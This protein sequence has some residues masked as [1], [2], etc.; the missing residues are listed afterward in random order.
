[1]GKIFFCLLQLVF[2]FPLTGQCQQDS[3]IKNILSKVKSFNT[4]FPTE[5][6]YLQFDKPYYAAGDT[7]YFKVYVTLGQEHLLSTKSSVI[8]IELIDANNKINKVIKLPLTGGITW[9]DITLP[10]SLSMGNYRIRAFTRWMRNEGEEVFFD[11]TIPIGN[12]GAANVPN[13]TKSTSTKKVNSQNDIQFL[14]EGGELVSGV[15]CKVAFKALDKE[16]KGIEV[17]GTITDKNKQITSFKSNP[18]GMG[19][20]NMNVEEGTFYKANIVYADGSRNIS[21]LPK[22][23]ER[24]VSLAVIDSTAKFTVAINSSKSYYR[25]N[26]NKK[27]FL[28][29]LEGGKAVTVK[30]GLDSTTVKFDV[31][32]QYLHSGVM[33]ITLF[34][35][36][37]EPL[38]ERLVFVQNPDLLKLSVINQKTVYGKHEKVLINL[39][40]TNATVI[41]VVG[42]FSVSVTDEGKVPLTDSTGQNI[43]TYLLLTSDLK[44]NIEKPGQYFSNTEEARKDLDVLM[45]THGYRRF[46][47]KQLL[48][49]KLPPLAFTA[50]TGLEINGFAKTLTGKPLKGGLVSLISIENGL[51]LNALT[52][53]KGEF[54]FNNLY[55]IDSVRFVLSATNAKGRNF[56]RLIYNKEVLPPLTVNNTYQI[57]SNTNELMASYLENKKLQQI[58]NLKLGLNNGIKLKAITIIGKKFDNHYYTSS[59]AGA[60]NADFVIHAKEFS[61]ISGLLSTRILAHLPGK[62]LPSII[63]IDGVRES[64]LDDLSADDVETV[65]ILRKG[66]NSAI[67]S[68][69]KLQFA[70]VVIITTKRAAGTDK[71][72]KTSTG[73]LPII[74]KGFYKAKEFYSPKY[75]YNQLKNFKEDLRSTIFWKP[76]VVTDNE[77]NAFFEYYNA[78]SVA[79][80]RVVI[81]GIDASGNLGRTVYE[82]KVE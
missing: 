80:Y 61:K 40:A 74:I 20:F 35:E 47:W 52:N 69:E 78:G 34:S 37:G 77:G 22:V 13:E 3:V 49:D 71:T 9:G 39:K 15:H 67:Y 76:N 43:L 1:M 57:P 62:G 21:D 17:K 5:K 46:T 4:N 38:S 54:S 53:D 44:G 11:Q 64:N 14:P 56:A 75:N 66:A 59:R 19:F 26:K 28:L 30:G 73:I 42:H 12:I 50:E 2:L 33:Q 10:D 29:I 48:E 8:N 45:L 79:N 6:A 63:I 23:P 60:G 41:P 58:E 16:G 18:L 68:D 72:N 65:E 55:F 7:I 70:D 25:D 36:T 82:Y 27:F 24:S 31:Q 81:E 51:I 32:K